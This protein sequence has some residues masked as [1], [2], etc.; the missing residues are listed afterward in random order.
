MREPLS[1][2]SL[3]DKKQ[4]WKREAQMFVASFCFAEQRGGAAFFWTS[5][6]YDCMGVDPTACYV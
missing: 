3:L 2:E 4:R 6:F 1:R 5:V